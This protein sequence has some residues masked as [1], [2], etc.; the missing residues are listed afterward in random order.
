MSILTLPAVQRRCTRHRRLN[1]HRRNPESVSHG[2]QN[3]LPVPVRADS[4]GVA[5]GGR[6]V[7]GIQPGQEPSQRGCRPHLGRSGYVAGGAHP[8]HTSGPERHHVG[9]IYDRWDRRSLAWNGSRTNGHQ[10]IANH[11]RPAAQSPSRPDSVTHSRPTP[12]AGF[13][14]GPDGRWRRIG[15]DRNRDRGERDAPQVRGNVANSPTVQALPAVQTP[16]RRPPVANQENRGRMQSAPQRIQP[17]SFGGN[18]RRPMDNA[19][20]SSRERVLDQRPGNEAVP[21]T[22]VDG[23]PIT[24]RSRADAQQD[25]PASA[26]TRVQTPQHIPP[27]AGVPVETGP[28][29]FQ[30]AM[31]QP[32]SFSPPAGRVE[33]PAMANSGNTEHPAAANPDRAMERPNVNSG[34]LVERSAD[35]PQSRGAEGR[36]NSN[37]GMGRGLRFGE[38]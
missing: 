12:G 33:R 26:P 17:P 5:T 11:Q 21:R 22:R 16:W 4:A 14:V 31:P 24:D 10:A 28:S 36:G 9:P 1:A 3:H 2:S 6:V 27:V 8:I 35:G 19:E 32:R 23:R 18:E 20:P 38:H 29:Q 37:G 15:D 25:R 13:V 30:R 34:R 7:R